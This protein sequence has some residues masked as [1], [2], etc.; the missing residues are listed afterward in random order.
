MLLIGLLSL[1]YV[2]F[3]VQRTELDTQE[4]VIELVHQ[5]DRIIQNESRQKAR[6]YESR[7]E[8]FI[9]V[10]PQLLQAL[11]EK[12]SNQLLSFTQT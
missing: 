5:T 7:I 2:V 11:D 9:T 6:F 1:G 3:L 10:N 12:D 8:D 4:H